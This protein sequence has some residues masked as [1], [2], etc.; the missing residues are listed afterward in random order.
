MGEAS[1]LV[2]MAYHGDEGRR[3]RRMIVTTM[4]ATSY[5]TFDFG[6]PKP[7]GRLGTG[8]RGTKETS[9]TTEIFRKSKE[10]Y[11]IP[12]RIHS[13]TTRTHPGTSRQAPN[14]K[15]RDRI[16]HPGITKISRFDSSPNLRYQKWRRRGWVGDVCETGLGGWGCLGLG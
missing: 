3:R 8:A 15:P 11:L 13:G 12:T 14:H 1:C 2:P 7:A 10:S 6:E 4:E 9:E 5:L 16:T